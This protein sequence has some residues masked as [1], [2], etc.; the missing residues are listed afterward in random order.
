MKKIF[1]C[2]VL[3]CIV[4][5]SFGQSVY[6]FLSQEN[7]LIKLKNNITG[8]DTLVTTVNLYVY[9]S[10][11]PKVKYKFEQLIQ[12]QI[13]SSGAARMINKER[14]R[15]EHI[16]QNS[17]IKYKYGVWRNPDSVKI[18][19]DNEIETEKIN[20]NSKKSFEKAKL[21]SIK[22]AKADSIQKI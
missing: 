1:T 10:L 6:R 16:C 15:S 7:G 19:Q 3:I 11:I 17:A 18:Y 14:N 13:L 9:K 8:K 12:R 2:L 4:N 20:G 22:K 21:D 5:C